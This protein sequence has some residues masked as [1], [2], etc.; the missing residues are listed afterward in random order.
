MRPDAAPDGHD[1]TSSALTRILVNVENLRGRRVGRLSAASSSPSVGHASDRGGM[2][3]RD[4]NSS[5]TTP[6]ADSPD[7]QLLAALTRTIANVETLRSRGATPVGSVTF[8]AGDDAHDVGD[9]TSE[10]YGVD[11]EFQDVGD[12]DRGVDRGS[13]QGDETVELSMIAWVGEQIRDVCGGRVV[14]L[15]LGVAM[16]DYFGR[17]VRSSPKNVFLKF[18]ATTAIRSVD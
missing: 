3:T 8:L 4:D 9:A 15:R 18:L 10:S 16:S 6:S 17:G 7:D 2:E 11:F 12:S 1:H 13:S 5:T 14:L